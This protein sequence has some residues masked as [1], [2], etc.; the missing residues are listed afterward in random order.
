MEVA[1][2]LNA[3][4]KGQETWAFATLWRFVL[5]AGRAAIGL[6]GADAF[7]SL[8]TNQLTTQPANS[9]TVLLIGGLCPFL[10]GDV[11]GALIGHCYNLAARAEIGLVDCSVP[12]SHRRIWSGARLLHFDGALAGPG[13]QC[14]V[15]RA[16]LSIVAGDNARAVE[17]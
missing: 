16:L 8:F 14:P 15:A 10:V 1:K 6:P 9:A 12:D 11:Y 2:R 17:P 7:L 3:A 5:G 13:W 4:L